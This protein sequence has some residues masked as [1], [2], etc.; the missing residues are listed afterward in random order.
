VFDDVTFNP[1]L[2]ASI[3]P[4][5]R[6]MLSSWGSNSSSSTSSETSTVAAFLELLLGLYMQHQ[7]DKIAALQDDRLLFELAMLEDLGCSEV[8]LSGVYSCPAGMVVAIA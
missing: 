8:L 7:K 5:L 2:E 6:Q 1:L 4:E 3:N